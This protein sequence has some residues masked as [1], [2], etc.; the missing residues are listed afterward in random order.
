MTF[1]TFI[2]RFVSPLW[3][4]YASGFVVLAA[5]NLV[6]LQIPQLAKQ[7]INKLT[8]TGGFAE[9]GARADAKSTALAI[10]G[11]GVLMILIR[12]L[13]RVVIFW[14][15]R[16]VETTTKSTFFAKML[17][18]P[19]TFFLRHGMG[20][21]ISRLSNDVGQLRAFFAFG[22]LQIMN[23]AFL[24]IFT[25]A[26]MLSEHPTLTLLTLAPLTLMVVITK[27]TMPMMHKSSRDNQNAVGSLTNRVTEA[28]VNVHVI[29]ANAAA[30][31]F[32]ERVAKENDEVYRTNMRMVY[33]RTMIFPLMTC[34]AGLSQL[35]V[36]GYGGLEV[37]R[38]HLTVGDILAFN[39]YIGLLT[40]PLTAMGI[41]LALYQRAKTALERL[42]EIDAT[43]SEGSASETKRPRED[44]TLLEV[45]HLTFTF[46]EAV[47]D[48]RGP[49][50]KDLSLKLAP[51]GRIGL[52]GKVGSGK[53]TLFNLVTRLFDPPVGAVFWRGQDVTT[54]VPRDL[55]QDVGYALQGVHLFSASIREN[56]AFG[57]EPAPGLEAL[58]AAAADAQI[59]T[60]IE[61][62]PDGWETQI[63]EKGVRL[64]GGQKQ[65]LALARLLLRKPPLMLLDDVLSAVDHSTE[66]RLIDRLYDLGSALIIASHRGSALKRCDEI[67]VL[68]DGQVEARGTYAALLGR[69][70]EL[71]L[72]A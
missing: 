69:Y 51:G 27:Y 46:P 39:V 60:E 24:L 36:L 4:W 48:G 21:L 52:F 43:P 29:Q 44:S 70:P 13:S 20:D 47:K 59:L 72:D 34:L 28:F 41:I 17:A 31:T 35:I 55:R 40:F 7:I 37:T 15:G 45:R 3:R 42:G 32:G 66:K 65:R 12:S 67:L 62:F 53:S 30:S 50:V 64:S 5:V 22:L 8:A 56:L 63:G 54:L 11:L 71:A 26:R 61:A 1:S 10:V 25:L 14:P 18:L 23:V 6:S 19:E 33:I 57:V 68:K 16:Q 38:G 2:R 49:A 58:R 9:A